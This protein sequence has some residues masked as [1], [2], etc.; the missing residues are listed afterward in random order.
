[1]RVY[2]N[3]G[4]VPLKE[5]RIS[6]LD[7]GFLYGDGI[8][9]TMRVYGGVVFMLEEHLKRLQRSAAFIGLT[10]PKGPGEMKASIYETIEA[11]HE[12][13]AYLRLTV[14]RG[15]GAIGLDPELCAR[16]TYIV[17]AEKL[18]PYPQ[19]F[20]ENGIKLHIT[21]VRRN[22]KEAVNPQIKSLNFLNNILARIEAKK[23]GADEAL[24]LNHE[25]LLAEGTVSNIFF[26]NGEG[27]LC[28]PRVDCGILD[29]ITRGVLLDIAGRLHINTM[30]GRFTPADLYSAR[31]VFIA[32]T[33]M[34]AMPVGKVDGAVFKVGETAK[35]L[36]AEYRKEVDAYTE[37]TR[38][39]GPSIWGEGE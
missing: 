35:L 15:A 28:T 14:S 33:I 9:E 23:A 4:L 2:L 38:A 26:V 6:V 39:A 27:A 13:E 19:G 24:M 12:K 30:E 17:F 10:L 37:N 25:G 7:H 8:Y 20:Y 22:L 1:M 5:A 11:N 16:P 36:A 3:D 29:G 18:K 34:E 32:S 21:A 31:E